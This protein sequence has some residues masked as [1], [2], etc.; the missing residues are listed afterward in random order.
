MA[1]TSFFLYIEMNTCFSIS[2]FFK[3][4]HS[5]ITPI[6]YSYNKPKQFAIL[7][8]ISLQCVCRYF[9]QHLCIYSSGVV[10]PV[11]FM[12]HETVCVSVQAPTRVQIRTYVRLYDCLELFSCGSLI[13]VSTRLFKCI[14]IPYNSLCLKSTLCFL[15]YWY[16]VKKWYFYSL[17]STVIFEGYS[18]GIQTFR[19]AISFTALKTSCLSLLLFIAS[20]CCDCQL[21][22]CLAARLKVMVLLLIL[23]SDTIMFLG[24]VS[25]CFPVWHLSDLLNLCLGAFH[26][27]QKKYQPLSLQIALL[28]S[29]LKIHVFNFTTI[30][31]V[32]YYM[33]FN[34]LYCIIPF[35]LS[36]R[37]SLYFILTYLLAH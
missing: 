18:S 30:W 2:A 20:R 12:S 23:N 22:M 37:Q 21:S 11:G 10:F 34:I 6:L 19:L 16:V 9:K 31:P 28:S 32:T 3:A 36:L 13:N 25:F 24:V 4:A 17:Y 26:Y 7:F 33:Y 15:Q 14:T 5:T 27:F 29:A 8:Y 1:F 35:G